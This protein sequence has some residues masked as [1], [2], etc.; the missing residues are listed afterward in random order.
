MATS[1]NSPA[2]YSGKPLVSKLGI[3]AG[4]KVAI[5]NAPEGYHTEVLGPLP[6]GCELC[7]GLEGGGFDV[8]Q[9]FVSWQAEIE[10]FFPRL[11]D[12]IRKSGMVWVSWPKKAAKLPGDLS[13]N[14]IRD[15]G[16]AIGLVDVKVCAVDERWSG[17]KF[18][19][20]TKDR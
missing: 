19:F 10:D 2:G 17:L 3:K 18:V 11:R 9:V 13:E 12:A 14:P 5:L 16:L 7:D 6:E 20:R 15:T 4:M 8:I 1:V